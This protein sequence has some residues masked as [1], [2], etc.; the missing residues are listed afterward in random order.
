M[1]LTVVVQ[2]LGMGGLENGDGN[3]QDRW[4]L[5]AQRMNGAAE[6]ADIVTLTASRSH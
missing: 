1:Q 6:R 3:P 2:N 5:L 4:P